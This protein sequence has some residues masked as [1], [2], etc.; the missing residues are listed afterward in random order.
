ML[1]NVTMLRMT[2]EGKVGKKPL[3]LKYEFDLQLSLL[4]I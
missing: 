4:F 1:Y 3:Q 2:E